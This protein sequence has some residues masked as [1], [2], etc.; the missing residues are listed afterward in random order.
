MVGLISKAVY[1]NEIL[2]L[3]ECCSA[4]NLT[5]NNTKTK[6]IILDFRRHRT[7]PAPLYINN[8]DRVERVQTFLSTIISAD[9]KCS[10]NSTAIIKKT[11]QRFHFLRVLKK[12]NLKENLLETFNRSAVESLRHTVSL[13]V[14][15]WGREEGIQRI[16]NTAQRIIGCPLPSLKHLYSSRCLSRAQNIDK[17]HSHPGS[18]LFK[19]LPSGR[20]YRCIKSRTNRLKDSVFPRA[21]ITLNTSMHW[22]LTQSI[23]VLYFCAI[24]TLSAVFSISLFLQCSTALYSS[25]ISSLFVQCFY[26]LIPNSFIQSQKSSFFC[27]LF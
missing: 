2:R 1:R 4:N 8:G 26:I 5:L 22:H 17:D 24:P 13:Y 14:L 10:V 21:I 12:N 9:L 16:I 20:H 23:C 15:Y 27:L 3:S 25:Q 11:Q 6:E 18:Q 7:D 19:L